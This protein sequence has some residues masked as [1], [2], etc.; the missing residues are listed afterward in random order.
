MQTGFL[1]ILEILGYVLRVV[2][3]L[4]F[5]VAAGWL[6]IRTVQW[7]KESWE[8]AAAVFLGVLASFVLIGHWVSGGGTLGAYGL[9]LGAGLLIWGLGGERSKG[10][11]A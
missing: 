11:E 4:V 5:G 3:A 7:Q 10:D 6:S 8:T 1:P 9:G 2:G